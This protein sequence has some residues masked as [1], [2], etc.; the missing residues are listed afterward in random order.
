M[1]RYGIL[2]ILIFIIVI[3]CLYQ[4]TR[5]CDIREK[6][7]GCVNENKSHSS[8]LSKPYMWVYWELINGATAPPPYISLCMDIMKKNVKNTFNVIFLNEKTIFNYLSD[9]RKDINTLPIALKTDYIRVRLLTQYGGLW[10]DA[11]TIIMTDLR[12]IADKLSKGIDYVGAGCTGGY[13]IDQEGYGRPSNGVMGSIKNGKLISRCLKALDV[14]LNAYY[15]TPLNLRKEL[16]YFELGKKIIWTEYD[17]LKKSE[18][19]Y[20]IYHVPSY[21]DGTRNKQG[22]WIAMDLIFT[23]PIEYSDINKLMFVMLV[24]SAYC[25]KNTHYNWFCGLSREDIL[26]GNYFVSELFRRAINVSQ[27]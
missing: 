25:G 13:C 2:L 18:P 10:V 6:M 19:N 24:N 8:S 11:D 27:C 1:M 5:E 22:Q 26:S 16:D 4:N 14:K 9:L 23:Q 17:E 7:C 3:C 12:E 20:V 15:Q 21:A